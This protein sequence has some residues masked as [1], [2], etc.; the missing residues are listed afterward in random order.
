M[1]VVVVEH[2]LV[3]ERLTRMRERATERPNF[4]RALRELSGLLVYEA[5]REQ[6]IVPLDIDTPMGPTVGIQLADVPLLVPVMRAG[7]GMLDAALEMLPDARTGFVGM[8][9]DEETLLPHAYVNTVPDELEDRDVFVLDPMLATGGSC[10]HTC[11][12]LRDSGAG[13]ITVLCV[14]SAPEGIETLRES[15]TADRLVTGAIDERLNE[16]GFIVPGLGDAGDRQFG[17]N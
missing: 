6:S 14:L 1:D 12:L 15:G 3:A 16:V 4:R 9:R 8:K 10:I 2:P 5:T 17:L 13:T 11:R 7:L